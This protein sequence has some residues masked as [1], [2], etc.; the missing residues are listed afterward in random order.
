[1]TS[2]ATR[3]FFVT[4]L[5]STYLFLFPIYYTLGS[6]IPTMICCRRPSILVL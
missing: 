1:L 4:N 6:N 5:H 3:V 2:G